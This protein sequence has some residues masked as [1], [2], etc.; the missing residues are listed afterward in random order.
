M[1]SWESIAQ[2]I[3]VPVGRVGVLCLLFMHPTQQS[4][5]IGSSVAA[6]G[7]L[8]RIWAAGYIDKGKALATAGPYSITRNPLYI[9]SLIMGLGVLVAGRLYWFLIPF[10]ILYLLLYIPVM[11]REE[12]ELRQGYG[13]AFIAYAGRVPRFFPSFRPASGPASSF[14]WARVRRNRE[15]LHIMVLVIAMLFLVAKSIYWP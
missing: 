5:V 8:I 13:D 10:G 3:R 9:G 2:K 15:H 4:L 6:I 1:A 12:Q 14:L 11:K 7:A